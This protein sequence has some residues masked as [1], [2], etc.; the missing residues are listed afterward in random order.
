[1]RNSKLIKRNI[2]FDKYGKKFIVDDLELS[3][4]TT[5]FWAYVTSPPGSIIVAVDKDKNIILVRQYRYTLNDFT[6]ECPAGAIDKNESFLE[7]AQRE[8][9]EET[10]YKSDNFINLGVYN[11]LPNETNH[12]CQ[13]FLATNCQYISPPT[14]DPFSE[15]YYEMT[16]ELHPF[17]DVFK[18]LGSKSSLIKSSEHTAAIFLA[19]RHLFEHNLL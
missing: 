1:M 11:D 15:K 12:S 5:N 19:H 13:I 8:L 9:L 17:L 2:L 16:T 3:D 18:S 6:Y 4:G 7:T 14:L 10:G